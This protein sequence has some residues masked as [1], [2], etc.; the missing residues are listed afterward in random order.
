MMSF[1]GSRISSF[2]SELTNKL[3][4]VYKVLALSIEEMKGL[5]KFTDCTDCKNRSVSP[6]ATI[7]TSHQKVDSNAASVLKPKDKR[8][9]GATPFTVDM[10]VDAANERSA[11]QASAERK[12]EEAFT[13]EEKK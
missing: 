11:T 4:C 7:A 9:A 13:Q 2:F 5:L 1:I 12:K 8:K 10:D 3:N 6:K